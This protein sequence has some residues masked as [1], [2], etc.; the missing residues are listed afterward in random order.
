MAK[1]LPQLEA[2]NVRVV[3]IGKCL[4]TDS[5]KHLREDEMSPAEALMYTVVVENIPHR[6][7]NFALHLLLTEM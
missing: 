5:H 6:Y 2:N 4:H 3:G 1:I 7:L